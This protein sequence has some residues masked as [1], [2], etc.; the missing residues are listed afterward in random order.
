MPAAR[1][2]LPKQKETTKQESLPQMNQ[3]D[4]SR[5]I[6]QF[7]DSENVIHEID[8]NSILEGGFPIDSETGDDMEYLSTH[9]LP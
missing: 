2:L 1:L 5:V 4:N 6:L 3:I 8:L 9:I 7:C